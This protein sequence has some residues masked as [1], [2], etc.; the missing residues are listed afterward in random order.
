[1][2]KQLSTLLKKDDDLGENVDEK[3]YGQGI[4]K[5]CE[6]VALK[7]QSIFQMKQRK[8]LSIENEQ[9]DD[10]KQANAGIFDLFQ[11]ISSPRVDLNHG[12]GSPL[13]FPTE[14]VNDDDFNENNEQV[15]HSSSS[16]QSPNDDGAK[17]DG[18]QDSGYEG[19]M[20]PP[21]VGPGSYSGLA[22]NGHDFEFSAMFDNIDQL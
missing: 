2:V 18:L 21:I 4:I 22:S 12:A 3:Q 6:K 16:G 11:V 7:N 13:A 20:E 14:D 5:Q 1:M 15:E 9:Q 19:V 17:D 8:S 10:G